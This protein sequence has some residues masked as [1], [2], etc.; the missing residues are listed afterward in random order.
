LRLEHHI[1]KGLSGPEGVVTALGLLRQRRDYAE[2]DRLVLDLRV[3][4]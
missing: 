4:T 1:A 2:R 3:R